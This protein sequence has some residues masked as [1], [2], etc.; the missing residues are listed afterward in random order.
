MRLGLAPAKQ[1][2]DGDPD[3]Q[4]PVGLPGPEQLPGGG[5]EGAGQRVV[6]AGQVTREHRQPGWGPVPAQSWMRTKNIR[7]LP[8]R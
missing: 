7:S 6:L 8:S 2:L 3:Q 5:V 4:P 1:H